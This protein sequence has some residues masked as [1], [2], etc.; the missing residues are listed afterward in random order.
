MDVSASTIMDSQA[1]SKYRSVLDKYITARTKHLLKCTQRPNFVR[2]SN[3]C[4][5]LV[6]T[7][8]YSLECPDSW[9][10]TRDLLVAAAPIMYQ[11][12]YRKEW[13]PYLKTGI[14]KSIEN[15]D[16]LTQAQLNYE[17]GFIYQNIGEL[18]NAQTHYEAGIS[19]IECAKDRS[20]Y[21][22]IVTKLAFVKRLQQLHDESEQLI[23]DL[24]HQLDS[25]EPEWGTSHLILGWIAFDK[26]EWQKSK[27][28]FSKALKVWNREDHPHSLARGL[29]DFATV[30]QMQKEYDTAIS[31]YTKALQIFEEI[32]EFHQA[33]VATM[34]LGVVYLFIL[35]PQQALAHFINAESKF[36][37]TQDLHHLALVYLNKGIAYREM[38]KLALSIDNLS[39]AIQIWEP[40]GSPDMLVNMLDELGIT[41]T[42]TNRMA[43]AVSTFNTALGYLEQINDKRVCDFYRKEVETH[44]AEAEAHC[45]TSAS[46]SN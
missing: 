39:S 15:N 10:P 6:Q 41:Y 38:A 5:K 12:G 2:S 23:L 8:Q 25:T 28:H 33:A 27:C 31:Y 18:Q 11:T 9:S 40:I 16:L 13:I 14:E 24:L 42:K 19:Q 22:K 36:R 7:L 17:L 21:A 26:L 45:C 43:E 30:L 20:I 46:Y 37:R 4:K 29:R 35:Q 3:N 44:L 32:S 34:N 1:Q